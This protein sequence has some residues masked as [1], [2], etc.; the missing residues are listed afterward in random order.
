MKRALHCLR[1]MEEAGQVLL[2]RTRA[3]D[4]G[5]ALAVGELSRRLAAQ[6]P[7]ERRRARQFPV[8]ILV[9]WERAALDSERLDY[10]RTRAWLRL[11]K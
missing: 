7:N 11:S 10:V 6:G 4:L 9:A 2:G 5:L 3:R 8:G 1:F